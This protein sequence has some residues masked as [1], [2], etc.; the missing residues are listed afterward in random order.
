[1]SIEPSLQTMVGREKDKIITAMKLLYFVVYSDQ[2]LLHYVEQCKVHMHFFTPDMHAS[3]EYS[4]YT[5]VTAMMG[6]LDAIA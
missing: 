1:M 6:F 2:P 3:M 4:H 5:N